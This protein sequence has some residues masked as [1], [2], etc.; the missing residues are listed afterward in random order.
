MEIADTDGNGTID[1]DEYKEMIIKLDDKQEED[2][3]KTIFDA[4]D[5]NRN[6]KL[7]VE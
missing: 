5:K 2:S 6:G 3:I 7:T 4:R 1:F